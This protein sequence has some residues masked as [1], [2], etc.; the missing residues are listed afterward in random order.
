MMGLGSRLAGILL[1]G[2]ILSSPA[3][4]D[5]EHLAVFTK[6]KLNPNYVAFRLGA[7][8]AAARL[9]ARTTHR[10]PDKPD[11]APEQIALLETTIREKP[12]AIL[13][14]PADDKA[15]E[16]TVREINKAGI[17]LLGFVNKMAVGEFVT[18][19]GSNDEEMGYETARYLLQHMR[20]KGT[21]VIVEGP[22]T[23]PT[24][25]DRVRG[26][27]RA[28]AEH[29][30]IRLLGSADGRYQTADA[31]RAMTKLLAEH[32]QIDGVI[33]ANDSMAIGVLAALDRAG[34]KAQVVGL[35]GTMEAARAIDEGRMLASEDYSGLV[36]GCLTAEAAIR[37]LRGQ[38]VPKEIMLPVRIIDRANVAEWLVPVEQRACPEWDKVVRGNG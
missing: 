28:L 26:F 16:P 36:L 17:P 21:V 30:G 4:A 20:G 12:G 37:H 18:F 32:P 1:A 7:D 2:A 29:P 31:D 38:P 10:V 27:K 14:A 5:G 15:L 9:G 24:S 35:N 13:L 6:N 3:Q 25:R 33:A 8:R 23:A 11:D 19:V 22:S 34:R